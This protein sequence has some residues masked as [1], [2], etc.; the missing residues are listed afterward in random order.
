MNEM[1]P[2][3]ELLLD[4][5]LDS[6]ITDSYKVSFGAATLDAVKAELAALNAQLNVPGIDSM[7]QANI[8]EKIQFLQS[9]AVYKSQNTTSS[10]SDALANLHKTNQWILI[11]IAA[12]LLMF[13]GSKILKHD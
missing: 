7:T 3:R 1:H 5:F 8:Q 11:G 4:T 2:D 10:P 9:L 6:K 13:F 12:A